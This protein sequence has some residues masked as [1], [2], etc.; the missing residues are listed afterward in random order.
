MSILAINGGQKIRTQLFEPYNSIGKEEKNAVNKVMDVGVL[1][2]FLGCWDED[3]F[4]G[5]EV[6][7]FESEWSQMFDAKHSISVN[8]NSSGIHAALGALGVGLGDE[9]IVSPYSMSVS[10]SAP[11]AWNATPV[12]A[13]IHPETFCLDPRSIRE[14]ITS[15]TKAIIVV[16]LFGYPSDMD[17]IMNIAR[18][19]GIGV[20]EDCAQAPGARYKGKQVG[21]LGDIGVFS[22][23][24]HKHIHCGEGGVCVTNDDDLATRLRLIRNHAEAVVEDMG[25]ENL[26][27]M[28]GYNFRLTEIQASIAREQIKKLDHEV[29]IRNEIAKVYNDALD[30]VPFIKIQQN[31]DCLHSYYV[32]PFCFDED[33]AGI[34]RDRYLEAV[35]AELPPVRTREAE[36]VPISGGYVKPLYL[37]PIFSKRVGYGDGYPFNK[38]VIYQKG[39][40]PVVEK[41]HYKELWTHDLCRSPLTKEDVLDVVKAYI[42]VSENIDELK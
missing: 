28:I 27:N 5:D 41:M 29:K 9:V 4:G 18:E 17:E 13:D 16:H 37:L 15:R 3:F 24:Y 21:T 11:I 12:F 42:K 7:A 33:I 30:S 31:Y 1:S 8:S 36:G 6:R 14:N 39:M 20:I 22:L 32:Q 38:S 40:C 35:R 10:A 34:S 2:K 26:Q 25:V 19:Y 23:N